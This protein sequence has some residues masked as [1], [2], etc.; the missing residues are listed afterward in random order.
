MAFISKK[1]VACNDSTKRVCGTYRGS[2]EKGKYKGDMYTCENKS[3]DMYYFR[4]KEMKRLSY[5]N[6]ANKPDV[7]DKSRR[8]N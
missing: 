7:F 6:T 5:E 2:D 8:I 3:C 4:E 1:C